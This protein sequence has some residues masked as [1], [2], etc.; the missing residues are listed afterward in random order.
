LLL[1][2][3]GEDRALRLWPDRAKHGGPKQN[4]G[5]ELPHD[6]RL[7]DPLHRLAHQAAYQE[8]QND[9]REEKCLRWSLHLRPPAASYRFSM[10]HQRRDR[11]SGLLTPPICVIMHD[12]ESPAILI[13]ANS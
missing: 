12:F 8:Q 7:P 3:R 5:D 6:G 13:G 10:R 4:S 2:T 11:A 1:R 9:L